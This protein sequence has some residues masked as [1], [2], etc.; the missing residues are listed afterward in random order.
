MVD[1]AIT[2]LI[3]R[4]LGVH[5]LTFRQNLPSTQGGSGDGTE[6]DI[7]GVLLADTEGYGLADYLEL[8]QANLGREVTEPSIP[9][10][11]E[12][13]IAAALW[14][15]DSAPR[16]QFEDEDGILH[17]FPTTGCQA[18]A[19]SEIYGVTVEVYERTRIGL[20]SI[21]EVVDQVISDPNLAAH[22][23]DWADCIADH[24][25][26]GIRTL[27]DL[28]D[29]VFETYAAFAEE[30]D[31]VSRLASWE[32]EMAAADSV[33]RAE[34]T[35]GAAVMDSFVAHGQQILAEHEELFNNARRIEMTAFANAMRVL[36]N[37]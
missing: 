27:G 17:S 3:N 31:G 11:E 36:G 8:Q 35:F 22:E 15:D 7:V 4:C 20:P 16:V 13:L 14:G 10:E 34:T 28:L 30:S 33:C 2:T 21:T 6:P 1:D 9:P 12:E 5:G 29:A 37:E 26:D 23:E 24:G 18:E 19:Q 25:Y 32:T